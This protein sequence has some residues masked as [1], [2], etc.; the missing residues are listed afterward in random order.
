MYSAIVQRHRDGVVDHH[1]GRQVALALARLAGLGQN[2]LHSV[3]RKRPGDH[4]KADVVS[5]TN[6]GWQAG[7]NTRHRCRSQKT[8]PVIWGF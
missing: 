2:L 5:H 4:A 7:R 8:R 1:V 6:A 3:R